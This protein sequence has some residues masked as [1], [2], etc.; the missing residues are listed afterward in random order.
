MRSLSAG[1]GK[2]NCVSSHSFCF[3]WLTS[4]GAAAPLPMRQLLLQTC[5]TGS[6]Y[7]THRHW[8]TAH[9]S[10]THN[11][12]GSC[13]CCGSR[14]RIWLRHWATRREVP[15]SIPS[16]VLKNF[17]VTYSFCLHSPTLRCTQPLTEMSTKEFI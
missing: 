4:E 6:R 1:L 16:V 10:L 8:M 15:G 13:R 17:Q 2:T 5:F 12:I 14:W 3:P 9:S 11:Y 7:Q